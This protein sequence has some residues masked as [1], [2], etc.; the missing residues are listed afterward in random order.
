MDPQKQNPPTSPPVPPDQSGNQSGLASNPVPAETGGVDIPPL[1]PEQNAG[2]AGGPPPPQDVGGSMATPVPGPEPSS[3]PPPS[4]TQTDVSGNVPPSTSTEENQQ[5]IPPEGGGRKAFPVK[6]VLI[7]LAVLVLL[8]GAAFA[9][10]TFLFKGTTP[11]QKEV[12][13][14]Y[15][16]LW[17]DSATMGELI[18]EYESQNPNVKIQ[19]TK[20]SKEDYRERLINSLT[21]ESNGDNEHLGKK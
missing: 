9:I 15:W 13:L 11:E 14:S 6:L 20:Q 8:V 18:R 19:Y 16:G 4:T 10:K 2:V 1:P 7:G 3:M 21:E 5:I 12:A 17:E